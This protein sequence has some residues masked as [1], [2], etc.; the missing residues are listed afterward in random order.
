[1]RVAGVVAK[2]VRGDKEANWDRVKVMIREAANNGADIVC[3]TE[4]FLDGYAIADKTLPL[5]KY[6]KLGEPIPD[7]TYA[8]RLIDLA[9]ELDIYLVAGILEA[10]GEDRFNT[11]LMIG[12]DGSI[13]GKYRKQQLGH[14]LERNTPGDESKVFSTP[15]GKLAVMICA[16]RSSPDITKGFIDKGAGFLLC[17]SGGMF[18]EK[19]NDPIL[20]ARSKENKLHIVFVHPAEFLVT[21]PD[22]SIA[23]RTILGDQL[24]VT[25]KEI[26]SKTDS[27]KVF[28]F[29]VPR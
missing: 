8:K 25:P 9:D 14:E 24:L 19:A 11:A 18:G 6:R 20:Q 23:A 1:M 2:W 3:T 12:P 5:E 29:D 10:D 17:P 15:Y 16:D 26:D 22:G 28:Y 13:I 27:K 7:G 21:A 4:C